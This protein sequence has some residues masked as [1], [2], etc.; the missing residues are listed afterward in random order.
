MSYTLKIWPQIFPAFDAEHPG[1]IAPSPV[2]GI[3][4]SDEA[5]KLRFAERM[6]EA[7]EAH[8]AESAQSLGQ[9]RAQVQTLGDVR[10]APLAKSDSPESLAST[11]GYWRWLRW[12]S[13][14]GADSSTTGVT[15]VPPKPAAIAE[16]PKSTSWLGG[17]MG[18]S[19]LDKDKDKKA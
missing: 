1:W 4:D 16:S 17:L 9:A 14:T 11:G 18:S 8:A 3:A 6:R 2:A 12:G 15:S 10:A 5:Q 7:E 19:G 13:G